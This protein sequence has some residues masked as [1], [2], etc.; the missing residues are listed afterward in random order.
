MAKTIRIHLSPAVLA[1]TAV[2]IA[3]A[4]G[5]AAWLAGYHYDCAARWKES[6]LRSYYRDGVCLVQAGS[7]WVPEQSVRIWVREPG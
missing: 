6:G 5:C 1:V 2:L 7:R 3:G 4:V